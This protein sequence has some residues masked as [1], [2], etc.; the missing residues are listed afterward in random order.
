MDER[1]PDSARG[2]YP[3]FLDANFILA[4]VFPDEVHHDAAWRLL[5]EFS[6]AVRNGAAPPVVSTRVLE[7]VVWT[8][9]R[10]LYDREHEPGAFAQL[11]P[12]G[13]FRLLSRQSR[14]LRQLATRLLSDDA[15]YRVLPLTADDCSAA[16]TLATARG[17]PLPDAMHVA[18]ARRLCGGFIVTNDRHMRALPDVTCITYGLPAE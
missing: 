18:M 16:F 14:P 3:V 8:S 4:C 17:I 6:E 9:C 13:Q 10:L 11:P 15:P 1:G 7:E 5:G 2:R 12:T